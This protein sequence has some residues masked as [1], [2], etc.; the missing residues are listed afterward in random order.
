MIKRLLFLATLIFTFSI[1]L[2]AGT[3]GK[4]SGIVTDAETGEALPG[5]NIL[6]EGSTMGAASDINGEYIINNI[7]P[8][9]YTLIISGVGFQKRRLLQVQVSADF[10]TNVDI[11]MST[12]S[13]TTETV[14]VQ[15]KNPMIRKDLTSSHTTV[16]A[17]T[18]ESLPVESIIAYITSW[19]NSRSRR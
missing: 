2:N 7:P 15:A 19:Y 18:I 13:I 8:G 11:E 4:I 9:K 1:Q 3:T 14:V 17:S 6:I 16:D 10:T 5:I 12:E